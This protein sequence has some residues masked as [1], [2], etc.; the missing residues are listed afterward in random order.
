MNYVG[1]K[2]RIAKKILKII[3]KDRQP[4]QLYVEPF[5]GGMNVAEHVANPRLLNDKN[6]HVSLMF[7][8][9]CDGTWTPPD[10]VSEEDYKL[11]SNKS[12]GNS[13]TKCYVGY[14][15][16]FGSKFFGGYRRSKLDDCTRQ[17]LSKINN[18]R[19]LN[20]RARS[21][22]ISQRE[23]LR[24]SRFASC[25][26]RDLVIPSGSLVYCDAPYRDSMG[27][28]KDKFDS[29]AFWEWAAKLSSRCQ[30]FVSEYSAPDGWKEVWFQPVTLMGK[31]E[32]TRTE[33]LFVYDQDLRPV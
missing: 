9:L 12:S 17:P 13:H 15:F 10:F 33:R 3:L 23:R 2:S 31:G 6:S 21:R 22:I 4:G 30:V 26:Y 14:S 19:I 24:G 16:S 1:S 29:D 8:A 27:Y 20:R 25:D 11:L 32:R 18:E 5:A 28:S 7:K